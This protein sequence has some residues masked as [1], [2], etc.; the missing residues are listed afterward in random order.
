MFTQVIAQAGK[1]HLAAHGSPFLTFI[2][3]FLSCGINHGVTVPKEFEVKKETNPLPF[4]WEGPKVQ[5]AFLCFEIF[6]HPR[7]EIQSDTK[8]ATVRREMWASFFKP[9]FKI[10]I[11]F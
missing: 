11:L 7:T 3:W 8:Q 5:L 1:L 6:K 9:P 2:V 10:L 4:S